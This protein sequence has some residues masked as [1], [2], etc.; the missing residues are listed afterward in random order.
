MSADNWGICPHCKKIND[1]ALVELRESIEKSYGVAPPEVYLSSLKN[2]Y[3][4]E[5]KEIEHTLREDYEL[6]INEISGMFSMHYSAYCS[7]CEFTFE[8]KH[9]QDTGALQHQPA[10]PKKKATRK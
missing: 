3:S 5:N 7:A 8:F 2:L 9:D 4:Q 6:Y 10:A 1:R